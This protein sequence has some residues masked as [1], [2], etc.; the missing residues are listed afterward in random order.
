[1]VIWSSIA[2]VKYLDISTF[3]CRIFIKYGWVVLISI[4]LLWDIGKFFILLWCHKTVLFLWYLWGIIRLIW[5]NMLTVINSNIV[6]H[7]RRYCNHW[8][9][10]HR[11]PFDLFM[12]WLFVTGVSL[13]RINGLMVRKSGWVEV[14]CRTREIRFGGLETAHKLL[15]VGGGI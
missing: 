1:M 9:I 6:I 13:S 5:G 2:I 11:V 12:S 4:Y 8:A 15:M 7:N 10:D 3:P 14:S